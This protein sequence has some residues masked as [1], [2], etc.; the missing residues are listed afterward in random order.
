M[1]DK[2]LS[3]Q[4]DAELSG[5]STRVLEMG[6]MVESQVARSVYSLTNFSAEIASEVLRAMITGEARRVNLTLPNEGLIPALPAECFVEVPA[7]VDA[8]GVSAAPIDRY[9]AQL[10]ALNRQDACDHAAR[11]ESLAEELDGDEYGRLYDMALDH[12]RSN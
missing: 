4:F 3:T 6:G 10:T 12:E 1:T 5:I 2:H 9:P 7:D 11:F 8:G